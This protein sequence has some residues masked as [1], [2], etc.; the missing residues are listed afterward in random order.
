MGNRRQGGFDDLNHR[1]A[2]RELLEA[3]LELILRS[4]GGFH[5][6]LEVVDDWA[7]AWPRPQVYNRRVRLQV[8]AD[9]QVQWAS[10][11]GQLKASYPACVSNWWH[12][13]HLTSDQPWSLQSLAPLAS[14]L[15][16]AFHCKPECFL[17][18]LI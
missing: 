14:V 16:L 8:G 18:Q 13:K 12:E 9:G 17:K 15:A 5:V 3:L 7:V 4:T 11:L 1:S 6:D 2:A 10:F